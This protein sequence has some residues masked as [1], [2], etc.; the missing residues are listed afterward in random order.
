MQGPETAHKG[1]AGNGG[2]LD[3]RLGLHIR[4]LAGMC[5]PRPFK[6]PQ[7]QRQWASTARWILSLWPNMAAINAGLFF[8]YGS[9]VGLPVMRECC[10]RARCTIRRQGRLAK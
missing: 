4:R 5:V 2:H 10:L 3:I 9:F 7:L 1:D 6:G 8:P